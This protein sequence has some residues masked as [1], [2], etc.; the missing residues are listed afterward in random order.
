MG[1]RRTCA[2]PWR[3]RR[4]KRGQRAQ[5]GRRHLGLGPGRGRVRRSGDRDAQSRGAC[6]PA[7]DRCRRAR[8]RARP[9]R[10]APART[11]DGGRKGE[12]EVVVEEGVRGDALRRVAAEDVGDAYA[13]EAHG[14]QDIGVH[15]EQDPERRPGDDEGEQDGAEHH[16]ARCKGVEAPSRPERGPLRLRGGP[17]LHKALRLFVGLHPRARGL[18]PP[19][20][21]SAAAAARH[22]QRP[23]AM[24]HSERAVDL[25]E[26][27]E[28]NRRA[29]GA[30]A[31]F[32]L[33]LERSR[34]RG[35]A[36]GRQRACR[37]VFC[38]PPCVSAR[39]CS[40]QTAWRRR[41]RPAAGR[42]FR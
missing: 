4:S 40:R 38:L 8:P 33:E 24:A 39:S 16:D 42:W 9:G 31:T 6:A 36:Y 10:W 30:A 2:G 27:I 37:G 25:D 21:W 5:P 32:R 13:H 41:S 11:R 34:V 23:W 3:A 1:W 20:K 28:A 7:G 35:P 26:A 14:G 17:G 29:Q 15:R 19:K 18:D 12:G 22:F